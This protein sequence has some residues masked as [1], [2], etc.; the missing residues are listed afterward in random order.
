MMNNNKMELNNSAH[1]MKVRGGGGRSQDQK[2]QTGTQQQQIKEQGQSSDLR[3]EPR[4]QNTGDNEQQHQQGTANDEQQGESGSGQQQETQEARHPG[5]TDKPSP[6][7][8][9]TD[10]GDQ[11][12]QPQRKTGRYGQ[13]LKENSRPQDL[14]PEGQDAGAVTLEQLDQAGNAPD[15]NTEDKNEGVA[16]LGGVSAMGPGMAILEQWL[17]QVEGD[18]AYLLHNAFRFEE[19]RYRRSKGGIVQESRPW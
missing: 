13:R 8:D 14:P 9:R 16:A 1:K 2:Q 6:N 17:N 18:P 10:D 3:H 5:T 15:H 11:S 7:D 19:E 4:D 12:N